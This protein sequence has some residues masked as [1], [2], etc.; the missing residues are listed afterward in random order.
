VATETQ[1]TRIASIFLDKAV[2]SLDYVPMHIVHRG[3]Q[4][5]EIE[6]GLSDMDRGV[7]PR[8]ILCIGAVGTG[9]TVLVRSLCRSLSN[10]ETKA[11]Y[12]NC[13]SM[14]TQGKILRKILAELGAPMN[15]GFGGDFYLAAFLDQLKR[16][17]W[18]ILILDEVDKLIEHEGSEYNEFFYTLSR[19]VSNVACV[20]LT[21]QMGFRY[22]LKQ[23]LDGRVQDTF[24]PEMIEFPDYQPFE[25]MD[26]LRDRCEIGLRPSSY[27]GG[28]IALLGRKSYEQGLGARGLL[29]SIR[30]AAELV[31]LQGRD[32]IT[33]QDIRDA[34]GRHSEDRDM[35]TIRHFPDIDKAIIRYVLAQGRVRKEAALNFY[36]TKIA[37]HFGMGPSATR[38]HERIKLLA[39]TYGILGREKIG[40]GRGRGVESYL[41][42]RP[43]MID[44]VKASLKADETHGTIS[45][46]VTAPAPTRP[47]PTAHATPTTITFDIQKQAE[48]KPPENKH[49]TFSETPGGAPSREG[50]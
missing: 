25:L 23:E 36:Q 46:Y 40:R 45:E 20:L 41:F 15:T 7:T 35:L 43:E 42:I 29:D 5:D 49:N 18:L 2:F 6:R 9:K 22:M 34:I 17:K 50:R 11:V 13:H 12:V 16:I 33:E 26:I 24:R 47:T 48:A 19:S 4:T 27:D 21:N 39:D 30:K 28:I 37:K 1:Q 32:K 44:I 31:E 8:P 3:Q 10:G 14:N 38:F